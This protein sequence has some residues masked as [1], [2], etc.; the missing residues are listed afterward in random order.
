MK[1]LHKSIIGLS[2]TAFGTTCLAVGAWWN[3]NDEAVETCS[4]VTASNVVSVGGMMDV[5]NQYFKTTSSVY[6]NE[7]MLDEA[8][9]LLL[10]AMDYI[11]I[12]VNSDEDQEFKNDYL[13]YKSYLVDITHYTDQ[14]AT[15]GFEEDLDALGYAG[16]SLVEFTKEY[17]RVKESCG[18]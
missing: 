5:V 7:T 16:S 2:V 15:H 11:N 18:R 8:N 3:S 4:G 9:G 10:E 12:E 13:T 6:L 1:N 17:Q 14:Y